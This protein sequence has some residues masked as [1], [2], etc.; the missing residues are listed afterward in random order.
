MQVPGAGPPLGPRL[1]L[2][3]CITA[4]IEI[5]VGGDLG[6]IGAM[7]ALMPLM[8]QGPG[9]ENTGMEPRSDGSAGGREQVG[10]HERNSTGHTQSLQY[11]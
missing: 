4:G 1:Q 9:Q 7:P 2:T 6:E 10:G 3:H 5:V 11:L 8:V